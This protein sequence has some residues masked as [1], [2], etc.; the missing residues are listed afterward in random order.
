MTYLIKQTP[1][2][3][4][5]EEII[6]VP[7][8]QEG[9]YSYYR[10]KK[11]GI[12][13]SKAINLVAKM[14][15]VDRKYINI[16]GMKDK[17][18]VTIQLISVQRGPTKNLKTEELELTFLGKSDTRLSLGMLEKNKFIITV[19]NV[20]KKP[21][22]VRWIPN[23]FDDQRF[24]KNGTNHLIGEALVRKQ[25]DVA[26]EYLSKEKNK[27]LKRAQ[28]VLC[29]KPSDMIGAL[30]NIPQRQL[31]LYI[32]AFQSFIFN[33]LLKQEVAEETYREAPYV[34]GKLFFSE[35]ENDIGKL[36]EEKQLQHQLPLIG[37]DTEEYDSVFKQYQLTP[38]EFIIRSIPGLTEAGNMRDTYVEVEDFIVKEIEKSVYTVTFT[39]CKGSYATIVIKAM[40][41]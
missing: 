38:R 8:Q 20:T 19:R 3:F 2:D 9:R 26:W 22:T 37:F 4:I 11:K 15:H 29:E 25:F 13:Q 31:R 32:H 10:L 41:G 6:N 35:K 39:L 16:A 34:L 18:A 33:E 24:G 12:E 36:T 17:V 23:Y 27:H 1:E 40:F 14:L 7:L 28:E 5:V 21:R 30:R